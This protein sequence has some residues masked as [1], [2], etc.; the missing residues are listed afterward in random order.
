MKKILSIFFSM[1]M[2]VNLGHFNVYAANNEIEDSFIRIYPE[3][4]S[5][6]ISVYKSMTDSSMYATFDAHDYNI[7]DDILLFVDEET[8]IRVGITYLDYTTDNANG[9]RF[10]GESTPAE[11]AWSAG[12]LPYGTS[13]LHPHI[14]NDFFYVGAD[15][16]VNAY[17]I[18]IQSAP[19]V[20]TSVTNSDWLLDANASILTSTATNNNHA[21]GLVTA[22][23]GRV[24][25]YVNVII[26]LYINNSGQVSI[27]WQ[28]EYIP[29]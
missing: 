15:F 22:L 6:N 16:I 26:H 25:D 21:H 11:E 10:G 9:M 8:G 7:G 3:E 4:V 29:K 1:L 17:P 27:H 18:V 28:Y 23:N 13:T 5:E 12:Y 24:G 19:R 2:V 14:S 20:V